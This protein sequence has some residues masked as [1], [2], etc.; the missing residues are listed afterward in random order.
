[1]PASLT[2]RRGLGNRVWGSE[3]EVEGVGLR[4]YDIG[5]RVKGLEL[6]V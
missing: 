4:A 1:M 6:R 3:F 2:W 5:F